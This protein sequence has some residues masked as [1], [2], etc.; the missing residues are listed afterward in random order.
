MDTEQ[1]GYKETKTTGMKF[2]NCTPGYSLLVHRR[3]E[4][5]LELRK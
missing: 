4:D 1:K 3:Y 2:T 5:F